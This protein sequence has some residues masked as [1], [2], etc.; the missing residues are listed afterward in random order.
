MERTFWKFDGLS[1][2][3]GLSGALVWSL[4]QCVNVQPRP[5]S[6]TPSTS[7]SA[8]PYA[9]PSRALSIIN[10]G[11]ATTVSIAFGSDSAVGPS[12][13]PCVDFGRLTCSFPIASK[14]TLDLSFSGYLNATFAFSSSVGCGSTKAE[15]NVSNPV[16]YDIA[17]VS[18]VDGFSVPVMVEV[19][20]FAFGAWRAVG[21]ERTFG[22]YPSGCDICVSAQKPSCDHPAGSEGCKDG[23][24]Y[25]P[26][27]PCQW[28]GT[29]FGGGKG[30]IKIIVGAVPS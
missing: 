7:A 10:V 25:A 3:F 6:P 1:F 23:T 26:D 4:A 24:Q 13:F 21:N 15:L 30:P 28:Q 16:W 18:L 29:T 19:E 8:K 20:S 14:Q 2:A 22:V 9:L 17:D 11:P 12:A 27:V 5:V